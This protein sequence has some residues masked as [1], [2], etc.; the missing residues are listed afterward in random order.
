MPHPPFALVELQENQDEKI[1]DARNVRAPLSACGA[2]T[3]APK[4]AVASHVAAPDTS[5]A[6]YHSF[7]FGLAQPPRAGYEVTPR[8]LEVQGRLRVLVKK[9]LEERALVETTDKADVV[10]KL[11]TGTGSGWLRPATP[12]TGQIPPERGQV[13]ALG[14]IGIDIYASASG[15]QIWQGS[16]FAEIDPMTIDDALLRRGVDHMLEGFGS[17]QSRSVAQAP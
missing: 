14:F 17:P 8:S 10:V 13:A 3:P 7:A 11:S 4:Y 12:T 1:I 9:A 6:N 2:A 16:A 5:F 15:T